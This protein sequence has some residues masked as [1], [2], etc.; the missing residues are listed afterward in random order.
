MRAMSLHSFARKNLQV[1]LTYG[2]V[3]LLLI[4]AQIISPG[5]LNVTSFSSWIRRISF[6]SIVSIGQTFVILS[7]GID[8]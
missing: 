3:V 7:G 4:A 8:L 6:L 5:F 2:V 1:I